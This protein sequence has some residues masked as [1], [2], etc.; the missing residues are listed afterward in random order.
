MPYLDAEKR[1]ESQRKYWNKKGRLN[2]KESIKTEISGELTYQEIVKGTFSKLVGSKDK[3]WEALAKIVEDLKNS[4]F[5]NRMAI[6]EIAERACIIKHGHHSEF[7]RHKSL[8]E[9]ARKAKI[10]PNTLARWIVVKNRVF[11]H[12]TPQEQNNFSLEAG[13]QAAH[14]VIKAKDVSE[15]KKVE[16]VRDEYLK[17]KNRTPDETRI[18]RL[19]SY[20]KTAHYQICKKDVLLKAKESDFNELKQ[21]VLDML[22]A[23]NA[24]KNSKERK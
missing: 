18:A 21:L 13:D 3:Q 19:F 2:R 12:L 14:V 23:F 6:A 17:I 20:L 15:N 4:I 5:I 7:L 10:H 24:A 9:F 16:F 11:V 8:R 1:R 22:K